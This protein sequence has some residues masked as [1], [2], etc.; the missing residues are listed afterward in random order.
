MTSFVCANCRGQFPDDDD[1][2]RARDELQRNFGIKFGDAPVESV[3]DACYSLIVEAF[4]DG[5]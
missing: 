5:R 2:D 1:E 3:C 4:T